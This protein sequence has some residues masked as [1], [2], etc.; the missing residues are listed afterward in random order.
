M[1]DLR[2][3]FG[4]LVAAHRRR[5]RMTQEQLAEAAELS[6]DMISKMEVGATGAR[7]PV[8]ERLAE[9][10]DVD[11]AEFFTSDVPGGTLK[12]GAYG[13]ISARLSQLDEPELI[14]IGGVIAAALDRPRPT[15]SGGSNTRISQVEARGTARRAKRAR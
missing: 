8:I 7:F 15:L 3:R 9:V 6:V 13:A 4:Q 2:K 14:W 12:S 11:P 1:Q 5:R 10:L